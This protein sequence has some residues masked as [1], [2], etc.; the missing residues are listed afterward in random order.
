MNRAFPL[1]IDPNGEIDPSS[2]RFGKQRLVQNKKLSKL[3]AAV[4]EAKSEPAPQIIIPAPAPD[5]PAGLLQKIISDLARF[6][7][8]AKE[9]NPLK[10]AKAQRLIFGIREISRE[11]EC[12]KMPIAVIVAC[13]IRDAPVIEELMNLEISCKTKGVHFL[14]NLL[15]RNQLG[16]AAGKTVRQTAIGIVSIEGANQTWKSLVALLQNT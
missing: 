10:A 1:K 13:N 2:V 9:E 4:L 8:R 5:S 16:K 7:R 11:L 6:Q 12:Q 15:S 3:K 14:N